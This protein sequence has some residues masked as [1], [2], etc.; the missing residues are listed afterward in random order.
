MTTTTTHCCMS[1]LVACCRKVF[2][3]EPPNPADTLRNRPLKHYLKRQKNRTAALSGIAR[4]YQLSD[5][6]KTELPIIMKGY[7][8]VHAFLLLAVA[9]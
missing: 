7:A 3:L 8:I 1:G 4:T 6:T 9:S 5:K 2:W